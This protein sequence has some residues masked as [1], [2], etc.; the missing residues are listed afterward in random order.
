M[1]DAYIIYGKC[2]NTF[3]FLVDGFIQLFRQKIFF[4][5]PIHVSTGVIQN[6]ASN[7]YYANNI[8]SNVKKKEKK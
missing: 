8:S 2:K 7:S 5:G 3:V 6:S 4:S 1:C